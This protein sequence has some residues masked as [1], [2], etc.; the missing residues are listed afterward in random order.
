MLIY[1][2]YEFNVVN[3]SEMIYYKYIICNLISLEY[4][5]LFNY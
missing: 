2:F 5:L 1:K 4:F 3:V